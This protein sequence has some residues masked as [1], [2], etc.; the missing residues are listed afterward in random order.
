MNTL[1]LPCLLLPAAA[2]V[3]LAARDAVP[4]EFVPALSPLATT[5][6]RPE[7]VDPPNPE[8]VD[9]AIRRGVGFLLARQNDD[10]SWGSHRTGRPVNVFAPVPGSH[11]AFHAAT[12]SLCIAALIECGGDDPAVAAA[13]DRAEHWMAVNLPSVRRAT[14]MAIYN[15]WAHIYAVQ[16]LAMMHRRHEGNPQRQ[17]AIVAHIEQQI[18]RLASY[19]FLTGGWAYYDF[20]LQ[21]RQPAGPS[22]SFVTAAGL[23]ALDEAR[24]VGVAIPQRL[25]DGAIASVQRQRK[26]DFSYAYAESHIRH[27]M[28]VVNRPPGSLG[29]SQAC[30]AALRIWGDP[31]VTDD[32]LAAWLDRLFARNGWLDI[33]RKRPIPHE[34]WFA[35]AGYFFYFGHYYAARCTDLLPP[36]RQAP[37]RHHSA[38]VLLA[39]QETDGSWWDFPLYDYHQQYGTAFALMTL[40]RC[41]E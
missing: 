35:V 15:N 4:K 3:L 38:H 27:P 16:A 2:L 36:E 18:G 12:T 21:T 33:G 23:V 14:P 5:G 25:V 39:L 6:P 19:E 29:R 41:R 34:S 17:E 30:N 31:L 24:Q 11:H 22:V 9:D 28:H 8:A 20:D 26:P 32:V 10:G 37:Y 7:P 1:R 40:A 13:L